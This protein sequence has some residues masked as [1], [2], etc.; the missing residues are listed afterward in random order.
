MVELWREPGDRLEADDRD[1]GED[2]CDDDGVERTAG[3]SERKMT[4]CRRHGEPTGGARSGSALFG[5]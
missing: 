1:A 2:E 3:V 4:V 5:A